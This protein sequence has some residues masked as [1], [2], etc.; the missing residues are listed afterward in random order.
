MYLYSESKWEKQQKTIKNLRRVTK[1]PGIP[2]PGWEYFL[3][4]W[5]PRWLCC[6]SVGMQKIETE[7]P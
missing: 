5:L 3:W 7:M 1:S 2:A 4:G 6:L